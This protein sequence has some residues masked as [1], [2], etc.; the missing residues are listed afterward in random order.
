MVQ[1]DVIKSLPENKLD[2][3]ELICK[4]GCDGTT[5]Q[6]TYKQKFSDGDGN[7]LYANILFISLVPCKSLIE[8]SHT[9]LFGK[10][11]IL[12]RQDFVAQLKLNSCTKL[13]KQ[14]GQKLIVSKRKEE[15]SCPFKL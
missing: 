6:S 4:W 7:K 11:H 13:P 12:R 9:P 10:M 3:L 2:D 8:T 14:L 1:S 5:G 15:T